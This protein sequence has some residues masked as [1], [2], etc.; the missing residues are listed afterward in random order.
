MGIIAP[1]PDVNGQVHCQFDVCQAR[2][3]LTA[4]VVLEPRSEGQSIFT[5]I[6]K[7]IS[8]EETVANKVNGVNL[9]IRSRCRP[10][11][12]GVIED[13]WLERICWCEGVS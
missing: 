13:I 9:W 6:A 5:V 1:I 8:I 11:L 2:V 10:W 3:N 7:I 4:R 12:D